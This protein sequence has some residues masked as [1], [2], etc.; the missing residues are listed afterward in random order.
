MKEGIAMTVFDYILW[1]AQ[2][3]AAL[4]VAGM[5]IYRLG[6]RLGWWRQRR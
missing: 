2:L 3:V 1:A 6:V 5:N 4:T